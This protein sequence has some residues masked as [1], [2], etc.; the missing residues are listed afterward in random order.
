MEVE[1]VLPQRTVRRQIGLAACALLALSLLSGC[2]SIVPA[3]G[4]DLK[5]AHARITSGNQ[6][7]DTPCGPIEYAIQGEGPPLLVVHGAGG[8][9]DQ[10]L[11][12]GAPLVKAGYRVIAVS[13][14][15]YLR[16]PLPRDA[17]PA[18]QAEA[19]VCLLDA[20]RITQVDVLAASA[21]SPSALQ[22]ALRHPERCTALVL[23]VPVIFAP[24][25]QETTAARHSGG[26]QIL[27]DTLWDSDFFVW[28]A[29]RLTPGIID[30]TLLGTPSDVVEHASPEEQARVVKMVAQILPV[31]PRWA[32]MR[33]DMKVIGR[34]RRY[35]L[36]R[37]SVPT[38]VVSS[39]D[40]EF[41]TYD[42][43]LYT[44]ANIPKARFIGYTTGGHMLV[45]DEDEAVTA[46]AAFLGG[47]SSPTPTAVGAQSH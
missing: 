47:G 19:Y 41:G 29:R 1:D 26:G 16:T 24:P 45:G 44:A 34:L 21:G 20:L 15:G 8:G 10:G 3:Y 23:V 18:A 5:A 14:F 31:E 46:I 6:V 11:I 17:S 43:A 27:L 4:R 12:I 39:F 28:L 36:E 35:D 40:D 32:G 9:F 37:V 38:L 30:D 22:F 2:A 13:R 25:G 33:N 42:A 7:A